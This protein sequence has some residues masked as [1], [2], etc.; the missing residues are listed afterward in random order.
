MTIDT[1]ELTNAAA[2][3]VIGALT[4][5]AAEPALAAGRRVWDWLKQKLGGQHTAT[6]AEVEA[7]PSKRSAPTKITAMLQDLLEANPSLAGELCRILEE[8]GG[9]QAIAQTANVHGGSN[10]TVQTAGSGNAV[11]IGR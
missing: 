8:R 6:V 10:T 9:V 2:G 11:T 4:Q 1:N 5:A 3:A 7:E